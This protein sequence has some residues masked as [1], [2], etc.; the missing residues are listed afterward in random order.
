MRRWRPLPRSFAEH[1]RRRAGST[2]AL[3]S[4]STVLQSAGHDGR[5]HRARSRYRRVASR[6]GTTPLQERY[7]NVANAM[8]LGAGV[9]LVRH[10]ARA[11]R[12]NKNIEHRTISRIA[13]EGAR[14]TG[15]S[16]L[17]P[18]RERDVSTLRGDQTAHSAFIATITRAAR[19]VWPPRRVHPPIS[20]TI[21]SLQQRNVGPPFPEAP[22]E[23]ALFRLPSR[24]QSARQGS[25]H[26]TLDFLC[27][28]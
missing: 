11:P 20:S 23:K 8:R 5:W 6:H 1:A 26:M 15:F 18:V 12:P 27:Y 13:L 3:S 24:E 19:P 28:R 10:P 2:A 25:R 21:R 14:S 7:R 16:A 4:R 17:R 22:G 9:A